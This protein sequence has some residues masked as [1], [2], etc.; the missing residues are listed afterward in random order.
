[1]CLAVPMQI[2]EIRPD[3][4][5][6]AELEGSRHVIDLSF[7][8]DVSLGVYVIVHAGYAIETLDQEEAK[9]T[10]SLFAEIVREAHADSP[11]TEPLG[12]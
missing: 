9:A 7:V 6:V 5:G 2:V 11:Y 3:G 12:T 10:L 8:T 4:K 1:M